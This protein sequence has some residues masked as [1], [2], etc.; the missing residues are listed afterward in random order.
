MHNVKYP[1]VR[2]KLVG[3]DGNAFAIIGRVTKALRKGGAPDADVKE[4]QQQA[5]SG[6]Y[7]VLLATCMK[8]VDAR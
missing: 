1:N 7:N 8:W 6:D 5:M 4:F 3:E 2:V